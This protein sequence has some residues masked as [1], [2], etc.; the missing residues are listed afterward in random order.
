MLDLKEDHLPI[1]CLRRD[2]LGF[3]R[4]YAGGERTVSSRDWWLSWTQPG[5]AHRFALVS[6]VAP[7]LLRSGDRQDEFR[8][9][10][11]GGWI[12]LPEI[13]SPE[14]RAAAL[15]KARRDFAHQLQS[16]RAGGRP[17]Q[18]LDEMLRLCRK[19]NIQAVLVLMPEGPVYRSW[20]AS[21][22]WQQIRGV[23][24]DLQQRHG[25]PL[26]DA[27][28]WFDSEDV[29][30]DSHHLLPAGAAAFTRRLGGEAL[31][32]LLR[33]GSFQTRREKRESE[34]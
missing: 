1:Q 22:V 30:L 2:D 34:Q 20:Y 9:E 29:F 33:K 21:E 4:R 32:P 10:D 11:R 5:Y 28:C 25:V 7:S 6:T 24:G 12:P 19:E 27:R 31:P 3:V 16:M 26:V 18:L 17:V 13:S 15:D 8:T 23:L 14:R